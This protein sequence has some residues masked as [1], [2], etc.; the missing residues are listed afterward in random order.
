MSDEVRY[1]IISA[2]ISA[3]IGFLVTL[4]LTKFVKSNKEQKDYNDNMKRLAISNTAMTLYHLWKECEHYGYRSTSDTLA[5]KNLA[6]PYFALG[7]DDYIHDIE[8][9]FYALPLR[10]AYEA[11]KQK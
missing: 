10:E 4:I 6:A 7:G 8:K 9:K 5:W 2:I 1:Y 11:P 3:V